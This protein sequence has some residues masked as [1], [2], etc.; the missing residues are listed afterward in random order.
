MAIACAS[1]LERRAAAAIT[2]AAS[3]ADPHSPWAAV[4]AWRLNSAGAQELILRDGDLETALRCSPL[5]GGALAVAAADTS[6][7]VQ[8]QP[9][10]AWLDGVRKAAAVTGSYAALTVFLDGTTWPLALVNRLKPPAGAGGG[11][12]RLLSPMP[13]RVLSLHT[14]VG[15][16]VAKGD[17]LVVLEAM[18]VQMRLVAP[19]D[20]SVAS[21]HAQPGDLVDEGIE[22][23]VFSEQDKH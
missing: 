16:I 8:L 3:R 19:Q 9:G 2:I 6:T 15:A 17:V 1:V 21:I 7:V 23:V 5:P 10:A 18:K 11:D 20:G 4:S 14:H 22:L 12:E 13:G